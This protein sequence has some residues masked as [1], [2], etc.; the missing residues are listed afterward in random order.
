MGGEKPP[1]LPVESHVKI[2]A[3]YTKANQLAFL[4]IA[5]LRGMIFLGEVCDSC[6][7]MSPSDSN[8]FIWTASKLL[9]ATRRFDAMVGTANHTACF[10]QGVAVRDDMGM[11]DGIIL[12]HR[13]LSMIEIG[14]G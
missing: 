1:F 14:E 8:F 9:S 12:G 10:E 13:A 4:E 3:N 5:D 2:G 6:R 11:V 7:G